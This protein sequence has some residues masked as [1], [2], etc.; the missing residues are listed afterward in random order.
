MI[1]EFFLSIPYFI[2]T[3][4]ISIV[5][6]GGGIPTEFVSAVHSIWGYVESFSFIVPVQT[7]LWCLT[8][9]LTFEAGVF[10]FQ[11]FNWLLK[12]LPHMN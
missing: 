7:L 1:T 2:L 12:K 5:P 3:A 6:T 11:A 10:V 8:I 9:T 4:L